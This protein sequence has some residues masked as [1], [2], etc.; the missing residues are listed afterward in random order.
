MT[1]GEVPEGIRAFIYH[2]TFSTNAIQLALRYGS[3]MGLIVSVI[4]LITGFYL[5]KVENDAQTN[6]HTTDTLTIEELVTID[7]ND[8][9]KNEVTG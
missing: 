8:T 2:S 4:M 9:A 6:F 1:S 7:L 5:R 3:L